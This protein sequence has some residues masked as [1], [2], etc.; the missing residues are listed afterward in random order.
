MC[1]INGIL[2]FLNTKL[3]TLKMENKEYANTNITTMLRFN[4]C[5]HFAKF[6]CFFSLFFKKKINYVLFNMELEYI[7]SFLFGNL[8]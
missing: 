2:T 8:P 3:T 1:L 5:Q 7:Y 6:S 4:K